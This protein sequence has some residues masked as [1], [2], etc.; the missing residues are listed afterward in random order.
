[1][2]RAFGDHNEVEAVGGLE[3][4]V[5]VV[6]DIGGGDAAVGGV[7]TCMIIKRIYVFAGEY[8]LPI[9]VGLDYFLMVFEVVFAGFFE[10]LDVE[11]FVGNF[12]G[13]LVHRAVGE[14]GVFGFYGALYGQLGNQSE[15]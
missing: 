3:H 11:A 9:V 5:D 12:L 15:F 7:I 6:A 10:F 4:I 1:M 2:L 14:V 8:P 13:D